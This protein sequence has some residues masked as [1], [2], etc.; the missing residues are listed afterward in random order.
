MSNT[1][2]W[3]RQGQDAFCRR[4]QTAV[5]ACVRPWGKSMDHG[6]PSGREEWAVPTKRK[7]SDEWQHQLRPDHGE[8]EGDAACADGLKTVKDT[9]CVLS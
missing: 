5:G 8:D 4:A 9:G 6:W 7:R 1:P 2:A 3:G